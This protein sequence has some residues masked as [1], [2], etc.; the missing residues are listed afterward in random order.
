MGGRS[1]LESTVLVVA[2]GLLTAAAVV[3]LLRR[4]MRRI[5]LV[6]P[7][8]LAVLTCAAGVNSYVGYVRSL[9]DF[10][11][12]L[13]LASGGNGE[14]EQTPPESLPAPGGVRVADASLPDP[15]LGIPTGRTRVLLPPGYDD[16]ARATERYPV[17]YLVHGYPSGGPDDWLG[18]GGAVQTLQA[19]ADAHAAPP[20]IVVAVDATA[21]TGTDWECLNVPGG[22]QLESY[23]TTTVPRAIDA[24]FRTLPDR[25]ERAIGGMSGGAF[26]ALNLGLR[27]QNTYSVI[28]ATEPSDDP[29][30]ALLAGH[31][32]LLRANTPRDYLPTLE[33]LQPLAVMLHAGVVARTDVDLAYRLGD[34][35]AGRG[36][37]VAV[38]IEPGEW[39]TWRTAR[40]GLPYL[41]AFA[42]EN[43]GKAPPPR[44]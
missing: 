6:V 41:L 1:P 37:N 19:M 25:G 2:L 11:R 5:A 22:P 34:Q 32:D 7:V 40:I 35:L 29:D 36:A 24:Q 30:T 23:L 38:R 17:V 33:L 8:L 12:L 16:P 3:V 14:A 10:A 43:F 13:L 20:V 21:G 9:D 28:L 39:H 26:C 44:H 4:R 31:P 42:G 27:H 18:P 15:Q